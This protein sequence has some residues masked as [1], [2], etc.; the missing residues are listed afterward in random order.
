[1]KL[2]FYLFQSKA[3][4]SSIEDFI[5]AIIRSKEISKEMKIKA[6]RNYTQVFSQIN[7]C[8]IIN[9]ALNIKE[10]DTVEVLMNGMLREMCQ[11][12]ERF[13]GIIAILK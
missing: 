4:T 9:D 6:L 10:I 1:V 5:I 11:E 12:A 13:E 3:D 2:N 7:H 8:K